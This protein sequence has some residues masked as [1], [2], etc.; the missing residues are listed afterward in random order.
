MKLVSLEDLGFRESKVY[1][2]RK[3]SMHALFTFLVLG[4][5]F[6]VSS[7]NQEEE[8][9]EEASLSSLKQ[10]MHSTNTSVHALIFLECMINEHVIMNLVSFKNS[11][12]HLF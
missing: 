3:L 4:K 1:E 9:E 2:C 7:I 5:A 10:C 12:P 6:G 11:T 8:E